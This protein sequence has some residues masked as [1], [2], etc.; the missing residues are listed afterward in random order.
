MKP[1][2]RVLIVDDDKAVRQSLSLILEDYEFQ[3]SAASTA[4]EAFDFIE[5]KHHH[6]AL[7][8][9]RLSDM[10]G[11]TLILNAYEKS[12]DTVYLVYTGSI[13]F[14]ISPALQK[15][16]MHKEHVFLKPIMD[17]ESFVIKI[18]ELAQG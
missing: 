2:T 10:D 4:D 18:R 16:G 7:V 6:V 1:V 14:A 13:G 15:I 5:R 3:V 9:I 17:M 8:D 12:P 11:E